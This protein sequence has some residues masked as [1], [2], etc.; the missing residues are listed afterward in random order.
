MKWLFV[1]TIVIAAVLGLIVI[2]IR[3]MK[4][5]RGKARTEFADYIRSNC[6]DI[7]L[8]MVDPK[9]IV[10]KV[11]GVSKTLKPQVIYLALSEIDLK[12][13]SARNR[14]FSEL[15]QRIRS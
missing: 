9:A 10:A 6:P 3:D 13:E 15:A 8:E 12:D 1:I 5:Y 7:N 14:V 11:N 2:F 4:Y